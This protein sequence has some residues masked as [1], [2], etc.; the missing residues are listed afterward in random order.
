[1][2]N[3]LT[4]VL[5]I[6]LMVVACSS[7][8][9]MSNGTGG[10][11]QTSDSGTSMVNPDS[12]N[13][14]NPDA[15]VTMDD[16]AGT[17]P[18]PDAGVDFTRDPACPMEAAWITTVSGKVT[19][20]MGGP[21]QGAWAQLCLIACESDMSTGAWDC[22]STISVCLP[23]ADSVADGTFEVLVPEANRCLLEMTMRNLQF[24]E[25]RATMYCHLDVENAE[26]AYNVD[27][28]LVLY[29]TVPAPNLPAEGDK[30]MTREVEFA[31]GLALSLAPN[32]YYG[33]YSLL[34]A[35]PVS[36][37][38]LCFVDDPSTVDA[39]YAFSPEGT[40]AV[41]FS[42]NSIKEISVKVPVPANSMASP[43]DK[44][45]LYVL[46]GLGCPDPASMEPGSNFIKE[47]DWA[48]FSTGT[49]DMSG[50]MIESE[51]GSGLP[52]L[53]WIKIEKE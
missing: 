29:P 12:G 9:K 15:G 28:S 41:D 52:C 44:Y 42:N 47:G 36:P 13:M 35:A 25:D 31:S 45:K 6:S 1:M 5:G 24:G 17:M 4:S 22:S 20:D 18:T 40:A 43:G 10:N 32:N 51:P 38:N 50:T 7:D 23:P 14:T 26:S 2:K 46:G 33:D 53:T 34:A 19:D 27:E 11:N 3:H 30:D 8:P 16:D 49:V 48:F 21:L 37:E 39:L